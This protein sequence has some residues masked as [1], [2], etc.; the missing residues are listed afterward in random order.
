MNPDSAISLSPLNNLYP[1]CKT[2]FV[3]RVGLGIFQQEMKHDIPK[4]LYQTSFIVFHEWCWHKYVRIWWLVYGAGRFS[5]LVIFTVIVKWN[6][7]MHLLPKNLSKFRPNSLRQDSVYFKS[8]AFVSSLQGDVFWAP[9]ALKLIFFILA[10]YREGIA[11][12]L[13]QIKPIL[14]NFLSIVVLYQQN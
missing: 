2:S 4:K 6:Q 11:V 1:L 10:F 14:I 13:D 3:L 9:C 5:L 8:E 12:E 7:F